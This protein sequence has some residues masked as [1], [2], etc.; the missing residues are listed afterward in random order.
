VRVPVE[1]LILNTRLHHDRAFGG[2]YRVLQRAAC[3]GGRARGVRWLWW[4]WRR[5]VGATPLRRALGR[6]LARRPGAIPISCPPHPESRPIRVLMSP[7]A[8]R[9]LAGSQERRVETPVA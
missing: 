2:R 1:P 9:D 6:A 4:A 7:E 8:C 5:A 3:P